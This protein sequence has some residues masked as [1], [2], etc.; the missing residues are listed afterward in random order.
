MATRWPRDIMARRLRSARSKSRRRALLEIYGESCGVW[1][2]IADVSAASPSGNMQCP[3]YRMKWRE[4]A[5]S[6]I[7]RPRQWAETSP[8]R[9]RRIARCLIK[10][11]QASPLAWREHIFEM[12]FLCP[13]TSA[14]ASRMSLLSSRPAFYRIIGAMAACHVAGAQRGMC[15]NRNFYN[16][17]AI[18]A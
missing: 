10:R 2:T 9:R 15:L 11:L 7:C 6:R 13:F 5:Q 14:A 8:R 18:D 12:Y 1:L 3:A 17:A 4:A 16:A